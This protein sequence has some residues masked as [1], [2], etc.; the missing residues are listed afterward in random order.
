MAIVVT[1]VPNANA[2]EPADA[3][4]SV[5]VIGKV[6]RRDYDVFALRLE[7]MVRMHGKLR[8]FVELVDFEGWSAGG[9]WEDVKL[10]FKHYLDFERIAVVGESEWEKA[11]TDLS[12]LFTAAVV[13]YFDVEDK[14]SAEA[15]VRER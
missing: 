15:W 12:T 7:E 10:A 4:F 6:E 9:L 3:L 2:R 5:Q 13:R 14:E 8:V 11:I 1:R